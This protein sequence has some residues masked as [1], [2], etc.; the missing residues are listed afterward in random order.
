MCKCTKYTEDLRNKEPDMMV[1][2]GFFPQRSVRI[3]DHP[4][5]VFVMARCSVR[6]VNKY[7]MF[8][9]AGL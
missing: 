3:A 2:S 5:F 8:P 4:G 1:G 7:P 6:E 9:S